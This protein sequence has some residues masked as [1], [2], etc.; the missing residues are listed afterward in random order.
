MAVM[1]AWVV[2]LEV[3]RHLNMIDQPPHRRLPVTGR[4]CTDI[5]SIRREWARIVCGV[6]VLEI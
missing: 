3:D 6:P 4:C 5:V 2:F 1:A